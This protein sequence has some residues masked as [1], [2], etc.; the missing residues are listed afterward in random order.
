M[1]QGVFTLNMTI[2]M[3]TADDIQIYNRE[4]RNQNFRIKR[5]AEQTEKNKT[6]T[7][8][9]IQQH[10]IIVYECVLMAA[11]DSLT[12]SHFFFIGSFLAR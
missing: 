8:T 4:N 11:L 5:Q 12:V 9:Y 2:F 7:T 1:A 10:R 6:P 3:A